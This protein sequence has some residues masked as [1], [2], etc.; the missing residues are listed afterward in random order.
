MTTHEDSSTPVWLQGRAAVIEQS[1]AS[2]WRDGVPDYHLS[3][4]EMLAQR[5]TAFDPG[6][7]EQIVEDLVKVFEMEVS[8][9]ADPQT[10]RS[11]VSEKFRTRLNG[12]PWADSADVVGVGTYNVL[13]GDSEYYDTTAES[14]DSSHQLF[15]TALPN[16]FFWEVLEVMSPPPVVSFKWRHWGTFDG[17]YKGQQPTG[18][19]I[20]MFGVTIA[21]VSEDLKIEQLEHFYDSDQLLKPLAKGCPVAGHGDPLAT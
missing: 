17:E 20:E 12:G 13:V 1:D 6:S 8:H 11:L 10:W 2:E 15:H 5:T 19:L 14:F 16:G 18:E 21:R 7:L 4:T 9:K 3:E